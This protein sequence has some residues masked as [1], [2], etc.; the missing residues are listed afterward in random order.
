VD[1]WDHR[2]DNA[3]LPAHINPGTIYKVPPPAGFGYLGDDVSVIEPVVVTPEV[4][5]INPFTVDPGTFDPSLQVY[6]GPLPQV[7]LSAPPVI[8]MTPY[9]Q[10]L[11]YNVPSLPNI[12]TP[13]LAYQPSGPITSNP[14]PGANAPSGGGS[15]NW[16]S[17]DVL[18]V[19]SLAT[20][21]FEADVTHQIPGAYGY[22]GI[23]PG[24]PVGPGG[25]TAASYA[26]MSPAQQAAYRA[27]YPAASLTAP[28][29]DLTSMFGGTTGMLLMGGSV[30][31]MVLLMGK[32]K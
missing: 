28:A 10:D 15:S 29:L 25:V 19:L 23:T 1:F 16:F 32:R 2:L 21:A 22:G 13:A 24:M 20:Q 4:A 31:L 8:D 26:A 6:A 7:D 18:P 12:P 3:P 11:S 27:M 5:G 30:L 14:A 9:L 17:Q